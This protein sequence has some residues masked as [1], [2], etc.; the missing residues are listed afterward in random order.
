MA[1]FHTNENIYIFK[2]QSFYSLCMCTIV[3]SV[4]KTAPISKKWLTGMG[5][6]MTIFVIKIENGF[7]PP[8]CSYNANMLLMQ[9]PSSPSYIRL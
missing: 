6:Q 7:L 1:L 4:T 2:S 3:S 5:S 8:I 9:S